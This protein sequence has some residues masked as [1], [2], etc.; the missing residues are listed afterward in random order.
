MSLWRN[1]LQNLGQSWNQR[2][3]IRLVY[4]IL[5]ALVYH[6]RVWRRVTQCCH[7]EC[8]SLHV[9]DLGFGLDHDQRLQS[10]RTYHICP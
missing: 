7:E 2:L 8:Y 6:V 9:E 1:R 5:H 3:P 10:T 4:F